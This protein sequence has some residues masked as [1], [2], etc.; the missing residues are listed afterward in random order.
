MKRV[1]IAFAI[2]LLVLTATAIWFFGT[3]NHKIGFEIVSFGVII[4]LV[5]LGLVLA[6]RRLSSA[7]RGEPH[8]D[9]LS[10]KIMQKTA[11]WSYYISLY[12]WVFMI[13]LKDRVTLDTEQVL[14]A[15]ILSMA[16]IWFICWIV[17]RLRGIRHE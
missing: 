17:I 7:K 16:V 5:G 14:S 11:A 12:M 13:W 1:W 8:E 4:V 10:K 3:E 6:F 15:G 2:A 9:E